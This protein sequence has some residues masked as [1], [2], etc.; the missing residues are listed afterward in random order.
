MKPTNYPACPECGSNEGWARQT[1][2]RVAQTDTLSKVDPK[3][4]RTLDTAVAGRLEVMHS[5]LQIVSPFESKF[6]YC[7]YCEKSPLISLQNEL[8]EIFEKVD[9]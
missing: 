4:G 1:S 9:R 8:C 7:V 2:W 6:W 3:N 5:E